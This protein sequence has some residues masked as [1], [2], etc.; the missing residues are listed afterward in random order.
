MSNGKTHEKINETL[1]GSVIV[2]SSSSA[3]TVFSQFTLYETVFMILGYF[4][5]TY[6]IGP[7]LDLR[8]NNFYRWRYL[9]FLW[10][11]YQNFKH[12]SIWTHGHLIGDVIRY[13][14][15]YSIVFLIYLAINSSTTGAFLPLETF[16]Q[17]NDFLSH[18]QIF[19][20]FFFI[21][22]VLSSS[23]HIITDVISSKS[24]KII[25]PF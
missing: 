8:S 11:P 12:R 18:F 17:L 2:L 7:D 9:R 24:K 23:V 25:K 5:G 3:V 15:M 6:F 14:Y 16:N 1:I 13:A 10:I 22:N 4:I 19:I 21:G 20:F